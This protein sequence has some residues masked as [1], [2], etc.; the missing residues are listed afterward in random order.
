MPRFREEGL[1]SGVVKEEE[2]PLS[3]LHIIIKN[4]GLGG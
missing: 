2:S 3:G 1:P 4:I